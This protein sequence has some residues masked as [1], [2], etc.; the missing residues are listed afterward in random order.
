MCTDLYQQGYGGRLHI[1]QGFVKR[2]VYMWK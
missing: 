1:K 2:K